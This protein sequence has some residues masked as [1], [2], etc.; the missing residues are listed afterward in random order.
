MGFNVSVCH[1]LS[2]CFKQNLD[3]LIHFSNRH[4]LVSEFIYVAGQTGRCAKVK[5]TF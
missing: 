1:L 3:M 2:V 4:L 5:I